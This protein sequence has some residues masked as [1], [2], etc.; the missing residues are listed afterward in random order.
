MTAPYFRPTHRMCQLFQVTGSLSSLGR[1]FLPKPSLG[2]LCQP[3]N[4]VTMDRVLVDDNGPHR[5]EIWNKA[6]ESTERMKN[7]FACV[8][9]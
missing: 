3:S 7:R 4:K 9:Q 5:Y 2:E 8:W 1:T 6:F